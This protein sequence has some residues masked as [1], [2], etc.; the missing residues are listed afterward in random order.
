MTKTIVAAIL[1]GVVPTAVFASP[2]ERKESGRPT[3]KTSNTTLRRPRA[4]TRTKGI[5]LNRAKLEL[6]LW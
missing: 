2:S 6:G 3:G 4:G 1:T 5:S